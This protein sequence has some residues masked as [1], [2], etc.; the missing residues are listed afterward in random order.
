MDEVNEATGGENPEATPVVAAEAEKQ[1]TTEVVTAPE[2]EPEAS[3]EGKEE[4]KDE[5]VE[6]QKSRTREFIDR[7]KQEKREA[8]RRARE[9]EE[10]LAR[11]KA[12][13]PRRE[14]FEDDED[15]QDARHAWREA[16]ARKQAIETETE[17]ARRQA[18]QAR[19]QAWQHRVREASAEIPDLEKVITDPT[20][21]ITPAMAEIIMDS[22]Y[23][24]QVAYKLAKNPALAAEIAQMSVREAARAIGR[25]EAEASPK[26]RTIS[27]APKPVDTVTARSGSAGFDPARASPEE[28]ARMFRESGR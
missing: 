11:L 13:K 7:L 16:M 1:E 25:L 22:D 3:A 15:Y 18:E 24:P 10:E 26:P 19:V 12:E 23:G 21:P 9:A 17:K 4:G 8:E 5:A 14:D 2:S 6:K 27:Q 28:L 20:V